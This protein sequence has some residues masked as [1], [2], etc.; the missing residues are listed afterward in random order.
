MLRLFLFVALFL[1]ISTIVHGVLPAVLDAELTMEAVVMLTASVA[2]GLLLLAAAEHRPLAD[3]GFPL[4][5]KAPRQFAI[6][7]LL[8]AGA[9]FVVCMLLVVVGVLRFQP[10][11]GSL[12]EWFTG[13]LTMFVMLL[14]PAAAEEALFR[15]YPFQK[16]VEGF[17]AVLATLAASLAF[18]V[19]HANNPSVNMFALVNIGAAGVMLSVAYLL[20][21]SLWFATGV[22]LG[23]NWSMAA[24]LDLPVSGLEIFDAPLYEPIDRGPAWLSGGAFGPEA[25]LAGLIGLTLAGAGVVWMT[26]KTA[27]LT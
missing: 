25:G 2:A 16:L 24:L 12:G 3:L 10:D 4:S 17:G 27:W 6:G 13:M 18:A 20:T 19:A 14:I 7:T 15:G 11:N 23:W 1:L 9:L 26:R 8:G 22:H 5:R 21:R